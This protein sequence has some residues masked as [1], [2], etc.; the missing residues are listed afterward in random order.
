MR[1]RL[2][3]STG[4]RFF[5]TGVIS[6]ARE[7]IVVMIVVVIVVVVVEGGIAARCGE[8][9]RSTTLGMGILCVVVTVF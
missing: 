7:G 4:Q 2:Q 3:P 6:C 5:L 1:R 9:T 8:E